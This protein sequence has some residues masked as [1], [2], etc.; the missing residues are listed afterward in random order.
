[1]EKII[2]PLESFNRTIVAPPD[3]SITHRAILFSSLAECDVVVYNALLGED[4]LS[5][6]EC[7]KRLG[8]NVWVEGERIRVQGVSN[9]KSV[10]LDVGNS[11]TTMR[12]LSGIL[13]GQENGHF[14]LD[15]DASIRKRPMG[16][17]I[18]PLKLMGGKLT[19]KE[20]KA[21]L[22]IE[23]GKL[24]GIEYHMPVASAQVKSAILLAG[25]NAEGETTVIET[26]KTRDHTERMLRHFGVEVVEEGLRVKVKPSKLQPKDV[27]VVGDIS[28]AAFALCLTAGL[29]NAKVVVE[30]V[31]IN[32]TR[33]GILRV[34]ESIGAKYS[35]VNRK[36]DF[37]PY[38][39]IVLENTPLKP[40]IIDSDLVPYLID[41][42][43]ILAVLAAT[44]KGTSVIKG[45]EELKVKESNRIDT[46]VNNLRL[47][48]ADIKATND[49]MIIHG[50]E[51]LKGGVTI[52][53]KGDHRIA[54]SMAIAGALSKK[55]VTIKDAECAFVSYP[56]FYE[57]LEGGIE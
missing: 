56:D 35:L 13:A 11:G 34:F 31:G 55:G 24:A 12:L 30:N 44:I 32:P 1:M 9:F 22:K 52:D 57:L 51:H 45:A 17:V 18:E 50:G 23:G 8:A 37:E 5:T 26:I 38:A 19:G 54:M 48:G 33:D 7:V 53:P 15:G 6:I 16:R 14:T 40:F 2:K 20:G 27:Q 42:I 25:L 10:S 3:K 21:P 46:V 28:S 41:E 43:P 39:D 47:M 4:C 36:D 29:K 49:G